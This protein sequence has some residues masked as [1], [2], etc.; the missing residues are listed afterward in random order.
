M[1]LEG[2]RKEGE[3]NYGLRCQTLGSTLCLLA[4]SAPRPRTLYFKY[5]NTIIPTFHN[6]K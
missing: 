3:T 5:K 1:K 6:I 4:L 2:M